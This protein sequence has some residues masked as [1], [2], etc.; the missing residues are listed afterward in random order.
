[1]NDSPIPRPISSRD[2]L[3][4]LDGI[5]G[6][7][8]FM[9]L[10]WHYGVT[11]SA[12]TPGTMWSYIAT[13]LGLTW[14]GVDLFFV[15]SGFLIGGILLDN[16]ASQN[17][18]SVFY[19]R[20]VFRI[21]PLYF[22]WLGL[23]FILSSALAG[24]GSFKWLFQD[25]LPYWSYLTYTQNFAMAHR[26]ALGPNWLAITWS[27]AIEE[28]YYLLLPFVIRYFPLRALPWIFGICIA[29]APIIRWSLFHYTHSG[30][31]GHV[32]LPG[33][34]DALLMGVSVAY[35]CRRPWFLY[36]VAANRR[37]LNGILAVLFLGVCGL[38]L[39]KVQGASYT[40]SLY[41]YT[42]VAL[43]Y[44]CL[45]LV[46]VTRPRGV[47]NRLLSLRPLVFLGAISYG[48]YII[49]QGISGIFHGLAHQTE[50]LIT[51][52]VDVLITVAALLTT[53]GLAWVSYRYFETPILR[54]GHRVRYQPRVTVQAAAH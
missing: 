25:P 18:F 48:V 15:L 38:V 35:L 20:R 54:I 14:T 47:I 7:A 50:P 36:W 28:Q 19:L 41:G 6:L 27:L 29:S 40:M 49:H 12:A 44:A 37:L 9:V 3:T 8:I 32:L 52:P 10:I 13:A 46:T 34:W 11:Q 30:L 31:P 1:M 4:A 5:R 24:D 45:L 42:L 39:R 16:R 17:L 2:H 43:F 51:S 21:F 26:E 53:L 23:F 33:R 22:F